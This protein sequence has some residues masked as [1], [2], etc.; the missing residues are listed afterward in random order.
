MT[1]SLAPQRE[2]RVQKNT[3][4]D[5]PTTPERQAAK[6]VATPDTFM[7]S[8]GERPGVPATPPQRRA[9]VAKRLRRQANGDGKSLGKHR[10]HSPDQPTTQ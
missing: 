7:Y 4:Y 8:A 2:Q 1:R 3:A 5:V 6:L 9:K 10:L